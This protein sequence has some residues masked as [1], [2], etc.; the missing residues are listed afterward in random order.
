MDKE[1][2]TIKE[3]ASM[4]DLSNFAILKYIYNGKIK[5]LKTDD[6]NIYLIH[7]NQIEYF[8][9]NILPVVKKNKKKRYG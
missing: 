6:N 5:A 2:Y 7:K 9:I 1:Y 3:I 4:F 8:R